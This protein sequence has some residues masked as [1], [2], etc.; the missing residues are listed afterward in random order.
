MDESLLYNPPLKA[1]SLP[2]VA[3]L[4]VP[5]LFLFSAL[6]YTLSKQQMPTMSLSNSSLYQGHTL[7]THCGQSVLNEIMDQIL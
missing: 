3:S 5:H 4:W 6:Q 2:E 1:F 7:T